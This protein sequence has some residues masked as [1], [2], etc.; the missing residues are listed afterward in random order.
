MSGLIRLNEV[1][2]FLCFCHLGEAKW[3]CSCLAC[4]CVCWRKLLCGVWR[5]VSTRDV[6]RRQNDV[7]VF[8]QLTPVWKVRRDRKRKKNPKRAELLKPASS[9]T[10]CQLVLD[11]DYGRYCIWPTLRSV[12]VCKQTKS[13]MIDFKQSFFGEGGADSLPF[14]HFF[15]T[16]SVFFFFSK[17]V[18]LLHFFFPFQHFGNVNTSKIDPDV[19]SCAQPPQTL[20]RQCVCVC[21]SKTSLPTFHSQ[22]VPVI[23][24]FCV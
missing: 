5:R 12:C 16:C 21:T 20:G 9:Y 17:S 23:A 13:T 22:T 8:I 4:V 14:Y 11:P 18:V 2:L 6:V 10:R 7:Q 24:W 19:T 3:K 15:G 1:Q